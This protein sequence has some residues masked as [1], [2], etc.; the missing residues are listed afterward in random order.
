M[1]VRSLDAT[2]VVAGFTDAVVRVDELA[3]TELPKRRVLVVENE[4]T[5]LALP[6]VCDAIAFFGSG[7]DVLRLGRIPWLRNQDVVY[8]ATSTR[9]ASSFSTG[10]AASSPMCAAPSWTS[11]P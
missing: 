4:I 6:P 9:T 3:H 2:P 8:W 10:S 1:R 7:F 11:T 5:F